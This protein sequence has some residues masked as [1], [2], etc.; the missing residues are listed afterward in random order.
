MSNLKNEIC[1]N[2]IVRDLYNFHIFSD[3]E[4]K[5]ENAALGKADPGKKN[6]LKKKFFMAGFT[7]A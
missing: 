7:N 5:F 4:E 1:W 2:F 6:C 3:E